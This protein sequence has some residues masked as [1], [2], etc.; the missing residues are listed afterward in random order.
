MQVKSC[1]EKGFLKNNS[2]GN[3]PSIHSENFFT[4][5]FFTAKNWL[6]IG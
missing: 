6:I 2:F 5:H 4:K 1:L 3:I